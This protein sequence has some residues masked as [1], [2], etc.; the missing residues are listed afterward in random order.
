LYL[1]NPLGIY[2]LHGNMWEW[3]SSAEGSS[4]IIRGGCWNGFGVYCTAAHRHGY[5]PGNALS[6]VG[7]RLLAVPSGDK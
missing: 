5:G 7:F 3:T 2:D 4:R 1:P 6:L